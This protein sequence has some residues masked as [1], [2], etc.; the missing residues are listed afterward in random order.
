[1]LKKEL[2]P[3]CFWP[4]V[5][6]KLNIIFLLRFNL[7][8]MTDLAALS[9]PLQQSGRLGQLPSAA[10]KPAA[11][12]A[13]I[14]SLQVLPPTPVIRDTL[15]SD[16]AF[17]GS[18]TQ[19]I[20]F[21]PG[22]NAAEKLLAATGTALQASTSNG[23]LANVGAPAVGATVGAVTAKALGGKMAPL[24]IL[25]AGVGSL[26]NRSVGIA[27]NTDEIAAAYHSGKTDAT[28]VDSVIQGVGMA[29]EIATVASAKKLIGA[30]EIPRRSPSTAPM[31]EGFRQYQ[32]DERLVGHQG[33][34]WQF[35]ETKGIPSPNQLAAVKGTA[36]VT[37]AQAFLNPT[38]NQKIAGAPIEA[39]VAKIP[40]EAQ[41]RELTPSATIKEGFEYAWVDKK[42]QMDYRVRIHGADLGVAAHNPQSTAAQGWIVRV[43]R[44]PVGQ[45]V[46]D[47]TAYLTLD[48]TYH[49]G[50][51]LKQL[52]AHKRQ[53]ETALLGAAPTPG[54]AQV[55][56]VGRMSTAVSAA[57]TGAAPLN[58]SAAS[59]VDKL[60]AK[61]S[62][63]IEHFHHSTHLAVGGLNRALN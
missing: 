31:S 27:R 30:A 13:P 34:G 15:A 40:K 53:L 25:G 6:V 37:G 41:L 51:E 29:L 17:Q 9:S 20:E 36:P 47:E 14:Q 42:S 57:A 5:D 26:V 39:I 61:V 38:E 16:A 12:V 2:Y 48:G 11:P 23:L 58:L 28:L 56:T 19:V 35:S 1:V 8:Y 3:V 33:E 63:Q 43:E 7:L 49:K 62:A 45:R 60:L 59:P 24:A 52:E 54:T 50:S 44:N 32:P 4:S 46:F 18:A 55:A 22:P 10:L 21:V